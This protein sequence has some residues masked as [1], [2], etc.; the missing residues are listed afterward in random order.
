MQGGRMVTGLVK[1]GDSITGVVAKNA[2]S[3]A[4]M[5]AGGRVL[6]RVRVRVR[7]RMEFDLCRN[8]LPHSP[9]PP[10]SKC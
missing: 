1:D 7:V 10:K 5:G 9:L 2:A 6:V 4:C 3:N 8:P